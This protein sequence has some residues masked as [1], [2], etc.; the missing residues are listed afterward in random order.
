[1]QKP[2][3]FIT[4]WAGEGE[5]KVKR[6]RGKNLTLFSSPLKGRNWVSSEYGALL[7]DGIIFMPFFLLL[8]CMTMLF[9][10][11]KLLENC[12]LS[13][14]RTFWALKC[15]C[16]WLTPLS[17]FNSL[18]SAEFMVYSGRVRYYHP[19]FIIK[20]FAITDE[21]SSWWASS[22]FRFAIREEFSSHDLRFRLKWC[23]HFNV[24]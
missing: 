1:M 3:D 21:Y 15:V 13:L 11:L 7:S 24:I 4:I 2:F 22:Y 12:R 14:S 19:Q 23:W 20:R 8:F 10:L 5:E 16:E 17:R 9:I 6:K 18:C